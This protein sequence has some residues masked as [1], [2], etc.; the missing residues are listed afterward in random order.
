M[1]GLAQLALYAWIRL[2]YSCIVEHIAH[3]CSWGLPITIADFVKPAVKSM[4]G[5]GA[6]AYILLFIVHDYT[7][8]LIFRGG[9][10]V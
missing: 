10:L 4:A 1:L 7:V 3:Y 8:H 5:V 2:L 9:L 6:E